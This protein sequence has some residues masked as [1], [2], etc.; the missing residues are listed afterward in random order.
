MH[1]LDTKLGRI[2]AFKECSAVGTVLC[3][4]L[5]PPLPLLTFRMGP[6]ELREVIAIGE[7][8]YVKF[9]PMCDRFVILDTN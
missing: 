6:A 9:I 3:I 2:V 1:T 4:P 7:D 5:L 8:V